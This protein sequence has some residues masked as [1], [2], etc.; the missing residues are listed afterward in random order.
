MTTNHR[1]VAGIS[2]RRPRPEVLAWAAA[3]AQARQAVL[4]LVSVCRPWRDDEV[5]LT[6]WA[7]VHEARRLVAERHPDVEVV[8]RAIAGDPEQ[9]LRAK[10]AGA[11]LLVVGADDQS[12]FV[13]AIVGSVP[14][15]LL[16]TAPCPMIV[17]P[18]DA[19]PVHD[20]APVVVGVD[21]AETSR[22]ALDY[23]FAAAARSGRDLHV[24]LCWTAPREPTEH[25]AEYAEEQRALA[26]ALAGY[27]ERYPDVIVTEFLVD[28]DPVTELARRA[29]H[30][31]LLVLGS[32]GRGRL[33]SLAFGSVSRTL[34]RSSPCPVAVS[35]PDL[36]TP[37][38]AAAGHRDSA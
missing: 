25:R 34:V 4:E 7:A 13:E 18:T 12:P 30:A 19:A 8:V 26:V 3:E 21:T 31:A 24:V 23:A 15:G 10:A 28:E 29:H 22:A 5:H 32:R 6:T 17:V 16:T 11:D 2:P 35:R 9:V 27:A 1:V 37:A 20:T 36:T 14:G 33:A 38:T